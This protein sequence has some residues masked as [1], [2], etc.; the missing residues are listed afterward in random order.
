[1]PQKTINQTRWISKGGIQFN[2]MV[3]VTKKKNLWGDTTNYETQK[4]Y[5]LYSWQ[6]NGQWRT[7][8]KQIQTEG[9]QN[10]FFQSKVSS[11]RSVQL[12]ITSVGVACYWQRGQCVTRLGTFLHTSVELNVSI[13]L[14]QRLVESYCFQWVILLVSNSKWPESITSD[15]IEEH[16]LQNSW[17]RLDWRCLICWSKNWVEGGIPL[18]RLVHLVVVGGGKYVGAVHQLIALDDDNGGAIGS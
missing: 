4:V 13:L 16:V 15:G 18:R 5:T 17:N 12:M 9:S 1:M 14:P 6:T 2:L 7:E 8:D 3:W 10:P 11:G